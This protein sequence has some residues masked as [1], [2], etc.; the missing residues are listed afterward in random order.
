[1]NQLTG[2]DA[3]LIK[4]KWIQ[5]YVYFKIYM[6]FLRWPFILVSTFVFTDFKKRIVILFVF[7][8]DIWHTELFISCAAKE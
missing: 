4:C 8:K 7:Q 6:A 3:S 1:M 5:S 2:S